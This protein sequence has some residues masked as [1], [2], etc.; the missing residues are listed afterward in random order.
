MESLEEFSINRIDLI[1]EK[2]N[3]KDVLRKNNRKSILESFEIEDERNRITE[4]MEYEYL[5][6]FI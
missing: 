6:K 3:S 4:E 2:E 1:G 5:R